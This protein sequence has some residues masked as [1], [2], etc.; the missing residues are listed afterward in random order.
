MDVRLEVFQQGTMP[1][2]VTPVVQHDQVDA[3]EKAD[4]LDNERRRQE[5]E[6]VEARRLARK[7]EVSVISREE[8]QQFLLL[9]GTTKG[10]EETLAT[11][12]HDRER[13]RDALLAARV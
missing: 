13:M 5:D 4:A 11:M 7:P 6:R 9:L 10:S 1:R 12:M 8:L 2:P 3:G